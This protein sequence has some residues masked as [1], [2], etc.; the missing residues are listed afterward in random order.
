[1]HLAPDIGYA[2]LQ[3]VFGPRHRIYPYIVIYVSGLKQ[4]PYI[5]TILHLYGNMYIRPHAMTIHIYQSYL[6][7]NKC[8][9]PQATATYTYRTYH[10]PDIDLHLK[11]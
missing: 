7:G 3:Y 4:W 6:H 10:V 9:R 8:V 5:F 1:M 2:H 11:R